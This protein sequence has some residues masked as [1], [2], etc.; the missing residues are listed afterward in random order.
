VT[1]VALPTKNPGDILTSALW[2]TY[3]QGN[4]D[5]GFA[6]KLADTTLAAAAAS[7]DFAS[8]PATFAH[9]LLICYLRGDT[10]AVSFDAMLRVNGDSGANYDDA[11]NYFTNVSTVTQRSD[12]GATSIT[13]SGGANLP[14]ANA[15]AN[16]E[17]V[18]EILIP[19][20][21]NTVNH[22]SVQWQG[23]GE[24]AAAAASF[25]NWIGAGRWKSTAAINELTLIAS[26]GN[27]AIGSRVELV[28]IPA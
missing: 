6:R 2:N 13:T 20:Y 28:G 22:K 19:H 23:H 26:V 11:I 1:Y 16:A 7:I 4:A 9:L 14:A 3:L 12:F 10:A 24:Q 5:S 27:F 18:L 8:I 25:Y 21:A 17:G 15:P